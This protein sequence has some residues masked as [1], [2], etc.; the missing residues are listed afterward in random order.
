MYNHGI[1]SVMMV[2]MSAAPNGI[3]RSILI[4]GGHSVPSQAILWY[5]IDSLSRFLQICL[6]LSIAGSHIPRSLN[7]LT[8]SLFLAGSGRAAGDGTPGLGSHA[9]WTHGEQHDAAEGHHAALRQRRYCAFL[10]QRGRW[11]P[12]VLRHLRLAIKDLF[13]S[14]LRLRTRADTGGMRSAKIPPFSA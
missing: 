7:K 12:A 11:T 13:I 8:L 14:A 2:M 9:R 10:G 6:P 1:A 4:A 5:G 3:L